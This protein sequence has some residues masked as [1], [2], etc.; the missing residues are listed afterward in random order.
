MKAHRHFVLQGQFLQKLSHRGGGLWLQLFSVLWSSPQCLV[1]WFQDRGRDQLAWRAVE[2]EDVD[3]WML[4]WV[5]CQ[6]QTHGWHCTITAAVLVKLVVHNKE[7]K[8]E[9]D[10]EK[11]KPEMD[12]QENKREMNLKENRQESLQ[13]RW[14]KGFFIGTTG[15]F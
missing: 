15:S 7:N 4:K 9:M 5:K 14:K 6:T 13:R 12:L 8:L 10:L 1:G 3:I 11:D 2:L